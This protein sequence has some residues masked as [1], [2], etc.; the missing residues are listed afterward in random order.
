MINT[1]LSFP[2]LPHCSLPGRF[3]FFSRDK[4]RMQASQKNVH[5][6][7]TFG[8]WSHSNRDDSYMEQGQEAL[9]HL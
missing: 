7:E 3:S 6:Q 8:E 5:F 2:S 4:K 1:V 9:Q